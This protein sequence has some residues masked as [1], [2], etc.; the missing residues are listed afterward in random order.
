MKR[1]IDLKVNLRIDRGLLVHMWTAM[2]L[3]VI[4]RDWWKILHFA[5]KNHQLIN[6]GIWCY[7]TTRSRLYTYVKHL[8]QKIHHVELTIYMPRPSYK[9]HNTW[10]KQLMSV[11]A[12]NSMNRW[13][14]SLNDT[15]IS[16]LAMI[17]FCYLNDKIT[18]Q[19]RL[20]D[21]QRTIDKNEAANP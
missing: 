13:F 19:K 2:P 17:P 14:K 16:F 12:G 5:Q 1:R 20:N 18:V 21:I 6:K 7:S 3:P 10:T 15:T 8:Y 4:Q 11:S 9:H